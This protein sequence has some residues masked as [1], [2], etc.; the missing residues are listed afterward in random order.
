MTLLAKII[1]HF[2]I[3]ISVKITAKLFFS[4]VTQPKTETEIFSFSI[5]LI[6]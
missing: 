1:T 6:I 2:A 5:P 3:T 4:H